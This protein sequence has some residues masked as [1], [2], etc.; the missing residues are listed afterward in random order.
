MSVAVPL[1]GTS[2]NVVAGVSVKS[3]SGLATLA[4][5]DEEA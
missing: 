1:E 4:V 3:D 5:A 2:N